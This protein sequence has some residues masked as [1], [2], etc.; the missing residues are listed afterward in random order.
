[1]WYFHHKRLFELA[2]NYQEKLK[3]IM[4][5]WK[6]KSPVVAF[7]ACLAHF[8]CDFFLLIRGLQSFSDFQELYQPLERH[9]FHYYYFLPWG[10][11]HSVASADILWIKFPAI[12]KICYKLQ[13]VIQK[14]F[15]LPE[16]LIGSAKLSWTTFHF[17]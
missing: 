11:V 16:S 3:I 1:M 10:W 6:K 14:G 7:L 5:I 8:F 17:A 12:Y 2:Q 4:W 13:N 15:F 9:Y